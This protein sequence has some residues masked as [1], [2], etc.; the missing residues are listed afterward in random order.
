MWH[1]CIKFVWIC[2]FSLIKS[3]LKVSLAFIP[4]TLAAEIITT[5]G[6][7][8]FKNKFTFFDQI[9]LRLVYF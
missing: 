3:A 7:F 8:F 2:K 1:P 4:P 9:N 6:L 5:F